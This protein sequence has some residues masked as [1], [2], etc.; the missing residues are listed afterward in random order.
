MSERNIEIE[1]AIPK[2]YLIEYWYEKDQEMPEI[3][4]EHVREMLEQGCTSGQLVHC[5]E[6]G[7]TNTGWW[8]IL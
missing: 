2:D 4:Q 5:N 3:E 1:A 8:K 7:N 6:K